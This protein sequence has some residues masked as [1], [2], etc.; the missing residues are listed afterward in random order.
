MLK[1]PRVTLRPFERDDVARQHALMG[2]RELVLPA[3]WSWEPIPLAVREQQFDRQLAE[4]GSG[5]I[6]GRFAI[7]VDGTYVG[8][9]SLHSRGINRAAQAAS[10]GIGIYHPDFVGKGYGREAIG[11]FLDW[12][13]RIQNFRRLWLGVLATNERA[14]RCYAACGFI[15]EG[16]QRQHAYVDGEYV[17]VVLMGLLRCEWEARGQ[18]GTAAPAS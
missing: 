12:A 17:D 4:E 6:V 7:D 1:G 2:N 13:F 10:F 14:I 16:R 11:L 9:I 15:E 8:E 18:D 5:R 3:F